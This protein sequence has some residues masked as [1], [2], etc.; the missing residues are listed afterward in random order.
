[1]TCTFIQYFDENKGYRFLLDGKFI[2]N[3]HVIFY[4]TE[5]NSF[6]EINHILSRLDKKNTKGK[7]KLN[8]SKKTIWFEKDFVSPEDIS[9]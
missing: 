8:K 9:L 2:V 7:G 4:E 6:D 1:M 5:S 3:R